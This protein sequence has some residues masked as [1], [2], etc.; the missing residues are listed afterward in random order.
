MILL[1]YEVFILFV[2]VVVLALDISSARTRDEEAGKVYDYDESDARHELVNRY[3]Q[4]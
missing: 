2:F 1:I 3:K 4:E